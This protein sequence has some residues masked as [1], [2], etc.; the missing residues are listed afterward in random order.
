MST[1]KAL[2]ALV[3]LLAFLI[4]AAS[5]AA[6]RNAA[7]VAPEVMAQIL[8][9]AGPQAAP[10]LPAV[11]FTGRQEK[12][13]SCSSAECATFC[14]NICAPCAGQVASQCRRLPNG[15]CSAICRCNIC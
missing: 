7:P 1:A 2:V 10:A 3:L 13:T 11:P 6:D 15:H 8:D 12:A 5:L 14:D 4:P 9:G